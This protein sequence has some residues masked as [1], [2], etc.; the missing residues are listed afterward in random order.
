MKSTI[1]T[2]TAEATINAMHIPRRTCVGCRGVRPQAELLRVR[3]ISD[4][5]LPDRSARTCANDHGQQA[6]GRSAYVCPARPC[7]EQAARRGGFARAF[8]AGKLSVDASGLWSAML[9]DLH[10]EIQQLSRSSRSAALPRVHN[11]Q[12]LAAAMHASGRVA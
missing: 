7:L 9:A 8:R 12:A 6:L 1:S 11:L 3:R 4:Q 2:T 10:H 5:V